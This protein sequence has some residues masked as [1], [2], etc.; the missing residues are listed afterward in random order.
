MSQFTKMNPTIKVQWL[1]D[2]RSGKYK[3]GC[4]VLKRTWHDGEVKHCCLGVLAEQ[5]VAAEIVKAEI[6][7]WASYSNTTIDGDVC[8]LS[9]KLL[10]WSGL[11]IKAENELIGFNDNDGATFAEIA[12]WIEENL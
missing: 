5:A 8:A 3:Q 7:Q 1:S 2:L 4:N 6:E 12:D 9:P 10:E 11:N